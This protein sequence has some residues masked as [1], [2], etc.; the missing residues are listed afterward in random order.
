MGRTCLN[1][2]P[3]PAY[4][5]DG[6]PQEESF[7]HSAALRSLAMSPAILAGVRELRPGR[8]P[9]L[10]A[11]KLV[12]RNPLDVHL[13]HQDASAGDELPPFHPDHVNCY[14]DSV[15]VLLS[16]ENMSPE[17]GLFVVEGSESIPRNATAAAPSP[18]SSCAEAG[19][20]RKYCAS[21]HQTV[22]SGTFWPCRQKN[23][24]KAN[25]RQTC[26]LRVA[27]LFGRQ[28]EEVRDDMQNWV[29]ANRVFEKKEGKQRC[30]GG[31]GQAA[32]RCRY[33]RRS[34]I[35]GFAGV[36]ACACVY[37]RAHTSR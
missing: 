11:T 30:W 36:R 1:D 33:S 8:V 2:C 5:H 26:Q 25:L 20:P 13:W 27:D 14:R 22:D 23:A 21:L 17:S 32:E 16:G 15:T 18:I 10:W 34:R 9:V 35:R 29:S 7:A 12:T 4:T 3:L 31:G 6:V 28:T 37:G 19:L 24:H